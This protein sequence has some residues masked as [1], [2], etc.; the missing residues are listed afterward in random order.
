[1]GSGIISYEYEKREKFEDYNMKADAELGTRSAILR[2]LTRRTPRKRFLLHLPCLWTSMRKKDYLR[3]I[4]ELKRC[5][6]L[7]PPRNR[8][9]SVPDLPRGQLIDSRTV[10][11]LR[12]MISL[13]FSNCHCRVRKCGIPIVGAVDDVENWG[14]TATRKLCLMSIRKIG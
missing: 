5:P 9:V 12:A 4:K 8:Q 10:V 1:M 6:E 14:V 7:S 3:Y 13:E 11:T 2:M